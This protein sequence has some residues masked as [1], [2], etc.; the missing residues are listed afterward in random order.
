MAA[1]VVG[2]GTASSAS[3]ASGV[4]SLR[5]GPGMWE[6]RT[7]AARVTG[8]DAAAVEGAGRSARRRTSAAAPSLG[9]H[10]MK[11]CS[12]SHTTREERTSS[13][14]V[15]FWYIASGL[16]TPWRRFFTTTRARWSF[17]TPEVRQ[18]RCARSPKNAG[19]AAR[20]AS[21]CHGSK[22]DDRMIPLGIF[23]VP[24]TSAVSYWP[25]RMAAAA[26]MRAAP[27]LAQPASTSTIGIPVMPSRLRTLCPVATPPYAV[28]QNAAWKPPLPTPASRSAARTAATPMS[29]VDTPS[30]LPKGC[31]PTPVT[32]TPVMTRPAP[33]LRI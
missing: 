5:T 27:P 11:R 19:V 21:S 18:R 23:S 6:R 13:T 10:S 16:A 8:A 3:P 4:D 7:A 20:P 17:V 9:E 2:A 25:A 12:G 30:N 28:P 15:S 33:A 1:R 22:K 29:V 14:V 31:I 26:S 24:K 32:A